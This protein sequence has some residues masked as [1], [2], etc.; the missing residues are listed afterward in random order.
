MRDPNGREL[1]TTKTPMRLAFEAAVADR[2]AR[3]GDLNGL[4]NLVGDTSPK[5][6]V[7]TRPS[8]TVSRRVK[9]GGN[10]GR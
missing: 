8:W 4:R 9:K 5:A 10:R 6:G 7:K 1:L 3:G 2:A